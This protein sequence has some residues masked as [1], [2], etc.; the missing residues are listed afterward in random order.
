MLT[1]YASTAF[2]AVLFAAAALANYLAPANALLG[3]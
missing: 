3:G 1:I 2:L